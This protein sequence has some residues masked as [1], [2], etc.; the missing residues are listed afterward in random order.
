ML[1]VWGAH[2]WLKVE[3]AWE[4]VWTEAVDQVSQALTKKKQIYIFGRV[5]TE[6]RRVQGGGLL[7]MEI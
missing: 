5:L 3:E 2:V 7:A 1:E 4:Q 6:V